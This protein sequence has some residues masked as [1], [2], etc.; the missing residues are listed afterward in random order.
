MVSGPSTACCGLTRVSAKKCHRIIRI[1]STESETLVGLLALFCHR[2]QTIPWPLCL[3]VAVRQHR[4][5]VSKLTGAAQ[6]RRVFVSSK[7]T[8][9]YGCCHL[10][11]PGT[12]SRQ[13]S[14]SSRS[15][16]CVFLEEETRR[17]GFL[18][19]AFVTPSTRRPRR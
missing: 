18:A 4:C 17:Q 3:R 16:V 2:R 14:R 13:S 12:S 19:Q 5:G 10:L 15:N 9:W 7:Q 1:C 8:N 6:S 11:Q